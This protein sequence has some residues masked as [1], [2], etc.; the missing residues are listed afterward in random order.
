MPRS[1]AILGLRATTRSTS[2]ITTGHR[3]HRLFPPRHR[4][5]KGHIRLPTDRFLC[6]R[7]NGGRTGGHGRKRVAGVGGLTWD[8]LTSFSFFL[9]NFMRAW[10]LP[11]LKEG[12]PKGTPHEAGHV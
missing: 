3:G 10:I 5:R 2:A 11:H 6:Q 12:M 4:G 8:I 7:A 1:A 9:Q